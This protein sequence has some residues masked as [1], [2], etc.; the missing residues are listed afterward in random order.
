MTTLLTFHSIVRWLVILAAVTAVVKL[1]FGWA[2]KQPFDKL[3]SALTAVFSGLMDTQLLLG[4]LFFIISGASIPGGFGLRYRWEHL[5]LMLFA[6]IVGHL[7][8]MWKK[9]PDE[10]RY[11]NTLLAILGALGLVAMGV[12]LLP[13]NRWLQISGLF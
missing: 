8:A 10:L 7:P 12:S 4:L 13:G 9:Q 1:A 11:R 2:Q 5:T 6:V 3:A